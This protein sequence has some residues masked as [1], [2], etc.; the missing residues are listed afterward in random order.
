LLRVLTLNNSSRNL[1]FS[2]RRLSISRFF[3]FNSS[4][5]WA[6]RGCSTWRDY[7]LR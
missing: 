3:W 6:R 1:S 7:K 4:C 5:S 2:N